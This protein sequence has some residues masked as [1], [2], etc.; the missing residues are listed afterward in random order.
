MVSGLRS[1]ICEYRRKPVENILGWGSTP[2]GTLRFK[3]IDGS[4]WNGETFRFADYTYYVGENW[5]GFYKATDVGYLRFIY[6]FGVI[7]LAAFSWFFC[8]VTA[9]CRKRFPRYAMFFGFLLL[10][11]FL[12]WFKVST[13]IFVVFAPFLCLA[14]EFL[15]NKVEEVGTLDK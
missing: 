4:F 9:V 13:D 11:N 10:L 5:H 3:K 8:A 6:Y 15:E 12:V 14:P 2:S 1:C 7:G